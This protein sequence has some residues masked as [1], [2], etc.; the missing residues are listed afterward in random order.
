M[1]ALA[2]LPHW[3]PEDDLL[4]K[5]AVE[6]GASLESLAKGAVR[7]S[8]RFTIRELQDRWHSLLY[9]ET[10][11]S[12][13]A[14]QLV[15]FEPSVPSFSK[16]NKSSNARGKEWNPKRTVDSVRSH[17]YAKRKRICNE[18]CNSME[19][20]FLVGPSSHLCNG[21]EDGNCM[22]GAPISNQF[23]LPDNGFDITARRYQSEA[24][25]DGFPD[26]IMGRDC[27]YGFTEDV[28]PNVVT[29]NSGSVHDFEADTLQKEMPQV[30]E[31]NLGVY[32]NC[33][34]VPEMGPPETVAVNG[35]FF[36]SN[37]LSVKSCSAFD[38]RN[39]NFGSPMSDCG[40]SFHQLEFSSPL[41]SLPIWKTIEE[42]T[43]P[44]LPIEP[45]IEDK[46]NSIL[47]GV[48]VK[49]MVPSQFDAAN[50][51]SKLK[52]SS[53][54]IPD[55]D[56]MDLQ[57]SL[58]NFA[59]EEEFFGID[60]DEKDLID[61]S[62]LD[63]LNSIF[64]SSPR[65]SD[66][67][68]S[69]GLDTGLV[70]SEGEF[71]DQVG[72]GMNPLQSR[73]GDSINSSDSGFDEV[74]A[75]SHDHSSP[76]LGQE[77]MICTL[78]TEDL[79]IPFNDD[80]FPPT[81]I[82]PDS[83][84]SANCIPKVEE[85]SDRNSEDGVIEIGEEK[86]MH[87]K[88]IAGST[89]ERSSDMNCHGM[90]SEFPPNE[91]LNMDKSA[92]IITMTE[93]MKTR[94]LQ[95]S[96]DLKNSTDSFLDLPVQALDLTKSYSHG[97][98]KPEINLKMSPSQIELASTEMRHVKPATEMPNSDFEESNPDSDDDVPYFS[99]VESMILDM[100]L[101]PGDED[102]FFA[103]EVSRYQ[104]EDTKKTIIR[105]EQAARSCI[106]RAMASHGALA[107]FYGR[108][109]KYYIKKPEVSIGRATEDISVDIDLGKE[110]RANKVSRRQ[111]TIKMEEDGAFY[112]TNL[113]KSYILVN[114][115]EVA[116]GQ[117]SNL[118]SSCLI[119]IRGMRF[120]FETNRNF[121]KPYATTNITAKKSN[122][123]TNARSQWLRDNNTSVG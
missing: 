9:N 79:E 22:M 119:E 78:N 75:T 93:D 55:G 74:T 6:A 26:G 89:M 10:I 24:I 48:D 92:T 110:G 96:V 113:G 30:I 97:N 33:S 85:P 103:R 1:G 118:S 29:G 44:V 46:E 123:D 42:L 28:S 51:E 112:L 68:G 27:L 63:G 59:S 62:C 101:G 82:Q 117:C 111:A 102:S 86:E 4:L 18:P 20:S 116:N 65:S 81:G 73:L 36:E 104:Y 90:S 77:F 32:S 61:R 100:D 13:V 94:E 35:N 19:M 53:H 76:K 41:P 57:S 87:I 38:P 120:M 8:R 108:H 49:E 84:E 3:V 115:K 60:V 54:A 56:F 72:G 114:S 88:S 34:E 40:G 91:E 12:K 15:V 71:P 121:I 99:D 23:E 7:F 11:A 21:S 5:N 2:P 43:A 105:L 67:K 95:K 122:H 70:I 47:P 66:P 64:L 14:D 17:Y 52:D 50:P 58:L 83:P 106:Q 69:V 80:I 39:S 109:L 37:D 16:P 45:N 107:V 31:E 25:E 98:C